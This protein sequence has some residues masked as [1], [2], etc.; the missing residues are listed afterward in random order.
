M[1]YFI[2]GYI[3]R[4]TLCV[5][6]IKPSSIRL[7]NVHGVRAMCQGPRPR[8]KGQVVNAKGQGAR[9]K[10]R[11]A[12]GLRGKEPRGMEPM[13]KGPR[14]MEPMAKGPRVKGR[15]QGAEGQGAEG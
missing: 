4:G 7:E 13:A 15:G 10:G 6:R 12:S 9:V 5:P 3:I 14:G 8:G 2:I 1:E 11:G